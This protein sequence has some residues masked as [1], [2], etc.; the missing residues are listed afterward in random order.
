MKNNPTR[1]KLIAHAMAKSLGVTSDLCAEE[2]HA[3]RDACVT[4]RTPKLRRQR[5]PKP[6][7]P[8]LGELGALPVSEHRWL[9]GAGA[10][11]DFSAA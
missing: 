10:L 2:V 11:S 7:S 4:L 3:L 8:V 5:T 9:F 1:N 6:A